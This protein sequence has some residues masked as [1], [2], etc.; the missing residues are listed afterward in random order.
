VLVGSLPLALPPEMT[1]RTS[2][3][4]DRGALLIVQSPIQKS[5][6]LWAR[7]DILHLGLKPASDLCLEAIGLVH[8]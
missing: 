8:A 2:T 1:I 4:V 5:K 7:P 3:D 6:K